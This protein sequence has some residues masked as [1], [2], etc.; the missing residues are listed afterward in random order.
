LRTSSND[1]SCVIWIPTEAGSVLVTGD[2]SKIIEYWLLQTH[3]ELF[4]VTALLVGHH[5]SHTSSATEFL[6]ASPEALLL[7]SSGDRYS[8]RWPNPDLVAYTQER[9]R[10]LYNTAELGTFALSVDKGQMTV[11]DHRSAFRRRW[12]K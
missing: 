8:P 6:D 11:S 1:T 10:Q 5:G 4:P 3:P 7:V 9:R 12:F 2:A